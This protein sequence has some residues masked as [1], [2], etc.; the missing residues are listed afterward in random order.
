MTNNGRYKTI[1]FKYFNLNFYLIFQK[2]GP[3]ELYLELFHSCICWYQ[4]LYI[5]YTQH[6]MRN[7]FFEPCFFSKLWV[8]VNWIKISNYVCKISDINCPDGYRSC[9]LKNNFLEAHQIKNNNQLKLYCLFIR[10]FKA[11]SWNKVLVYNTNL[12]INGIYYVKI[13]TIKLWNSINNKWETYATMNIKI[14]QSISVVADLSH[15]SFV[16]I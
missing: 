15:Q 3:F 5:P 6:A 11:K 16:P 14:L 7:H 4:W 9:F 13:D 1:I 2:Y 12:I 10:Q 8:Q